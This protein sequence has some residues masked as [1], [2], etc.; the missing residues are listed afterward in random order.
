[1]ILGSN[2]SDSV[3]LPVNDSIDKILIKYCNFIYYKLYNSNV[4]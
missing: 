1:M 2:P 4:K 3:I